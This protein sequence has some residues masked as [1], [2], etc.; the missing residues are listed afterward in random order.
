MSDAETD[1]DGETELLAKKAVVT[2]TTAE[3]VL[4]GTAAE[5]KA[6]SY[7]RAK[8]HSRLF[9]LLQEEC[10]RDDE[11]A[12]LEAQEADHAENGEQKMIAVDTNTKAES[13]GVSENG[14]SS[15]LRAPAAAKGFRAGSLSFD[16]SSS[17]SGSSGLLS[18]I[19]REQVLVDIINEFQS[20]HRDKN[21]KLS[22]G[23]PSK[24]FKLLQH[25][26][27]EEFYDTFDFQD[28]EET[29]T[30]P[31]VRL[32]FHRDLVQSLV[33][34][35]TIHRSESAG[36]IA[37][38]IAE[39]EEEA[40]TK[41][42]TTQSIKKKITKVQHAITAGH[43]KSTTKGSGGKEKKIKAEAD[44]LEVPLRGSSLAKATPSSLLSRDPRVPKTKKLRTKE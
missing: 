37:N 33:Q 17:P 7:Q 25:E 42:A 40:K 34:E 5:R 23:F 28:D 13:E 20:R 11:E 36:K 6:L 31:Q 15:L 26:F 2:T 8:T 30:L 39:E 10:G 41:E 4:R 14:R 21:R 27:G 12:E 16:S 19:N 18:P 24:V 9:Q 35:C 3:V 44:L 29:F 1:N 32:P 22:S 38:I 43:T